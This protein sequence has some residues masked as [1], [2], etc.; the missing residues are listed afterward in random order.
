VK[1]TPRPS[2]TPTVSPTPAPR[3]SNSPAANADI[4]SI[5]P[6]PSGSSANVQIDNLLPG[7]KVKVTISDL[8]QLPTA[9]PTAKPTSKPTTKPTPKPSPTKKAVTIVPK[10]EQSGTKVGIQNL[11]PGQKV[12]VTIKSGARP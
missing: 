10:P 5:A 11:K 12:K 8:S 2:A 3:A 7:Q 6:K 9:A 4:L 1:P